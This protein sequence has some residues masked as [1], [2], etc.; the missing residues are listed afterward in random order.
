MSTYHPRKRR[1]QQEFNGLASIYHTEDL[2]GINQVL[3]SS[4]IQHKHITSTTSYRNLHERVGQFAM[5]VYVTDN[6]VASVVNKDIHSESHQVG[7][8]FRKLRFPQLK[9]R[10][11]RLSWNHRI[12]DCQ[13][14]FRFRT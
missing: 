10:S 6:A 9:A 13:D 2:T 1:A 4:D 11:R 5:S 14:I 7:G 3:R 8:A 12:W